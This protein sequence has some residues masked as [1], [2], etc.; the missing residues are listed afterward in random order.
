[1]GDDTTKMLFKVAL[2]GLA[3]YFVYNWLQSSG[4]WGQIF[5]FS[6]VSQLQTYCTA[7]PSGTATYNG[8]SATCQQWL[9]ALAAATA[10]TT[11][12]TTTAPAAP[13][14]PAT[15][16]PAAVKSALSS[17]LAN[18]ATQNGYP[19]SLDMSQWNYILAQ[20]VPGAAPV[21]ND[22]TGG[23]PMAA[24]TYVQFLLTMPGYSTTNISASYG[25]S[26][27]MPA[28]VRRSYDWVM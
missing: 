1:M 3:G 2:L 20:L 4:Y 13:A 10:P 17:A 15:P 26:G 21:L 12:P 27:R 24:A 14:A 19:T 25:L 9:S 22:T 8:Q 11:A 18:W 5:G 16:P 28:V 23:Q 6:S 7:N